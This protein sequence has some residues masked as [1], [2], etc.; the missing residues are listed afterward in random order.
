MNVNHDTYID[1]YDI[2]AILVLKKL[3]QFRLSDEQMLRTT[4]K[5]QSH[6]VVTRCPGVDVRAFDS[7][8][9]FSRGARGHDAGWSVARTRRR[10]P[11]VCMLADRS[12]RAKGDSLR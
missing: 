4:S 9:A 1:E 10:A 6:R 2:A 8:T 7:G 11:S 3:G 12:V 5:D